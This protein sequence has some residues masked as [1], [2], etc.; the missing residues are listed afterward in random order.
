MRGARHGRLA[1]AFGIALAL[2]LASVASAQT[3]EQALA[4]AYMNNPTLRSQRANLRSVDENVSIA[5]SGWR[6]SVSANA[7]AGPLYSGVRSRQRETQLLGPHSQSITITQPVFQ[8]FRTVAGI[9]QAESQVLAGRAA[10]QS[11][12][13]SVLLDGVTSFMNVVRDQAV[14]DL[15]INNEQVIRRQLEATQDRFRVGEVTRT[16]VAQAQSRLALATAQRIAAEGTLLTSRA[17]YQRVIGSYPGKLDAPKP[18]LDL[19]TS[20]EDAIA[21][22]AGDNPAVATAQYNEKAALA[23]VTVTTGQLL[24]EINILGELFRQDTIGG[25]S[26][27]LQEG[28]QV[29]AV[30]SMPLY[31]SGS[32]EAQVRQAKQVA[33]QRRIQIEE[34]RNLAVEFAIS[35]WENWTSAKAQIVSFKEQVEA[36]RIAL[37]G[38]RQENLVGSRTVLDVLDA[39]QEYLNAQVSLVRAERD[40][41]VARYQLVSAIG[42][43]TARNLSLDVPYYDEADHY[44]KVR[45]KWIGL[46][47]YRGYD[48]ATQQP[49]KD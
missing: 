18:A 9:R 40:E 31:S 6:P 2:A 46:D 16:D 10:L 11:T 12:E 7:A 28:A 4:E 14:L 13:Q 1:A 29:T 39:E 26:N 44:G 38:V 27:A 47:G 49:D 3:L 25:L 43:L 37:D 15:N 36:S 33:G 5:E 30:L 48:K 34:Q 32:V 8:G 41:L 21:L 23:N 22:A 35:A 17:T 20:R 19:P 42:K 24:P 45:D